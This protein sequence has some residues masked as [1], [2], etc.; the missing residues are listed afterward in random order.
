M[1]AIIIITPEPSD[2]GDL[3]DLAYLDDISDTCAEIEFTEPYS[4]GKYIYNTMGWLHID[5]GVKKE[6]IDVMHDA[7]CCIFI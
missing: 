7:Y 6:I 4:P 5:F 1:E 2:L 3:A